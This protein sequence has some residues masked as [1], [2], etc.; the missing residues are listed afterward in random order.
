M[1]CSAEDHWDSTCNGE[2]GGIR[3]DGKAVSLKN[4]IMEKSGLYNHYNRFRNLLLSGKTGQVYIE[5]CCSFHTFTI[6]V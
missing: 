6:I 5:S 1:G 3:K 4:D 2:I